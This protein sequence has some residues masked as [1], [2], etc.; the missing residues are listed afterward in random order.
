M[1]TLNSKFRD[2]RAMEAFVA[3]VS[4]GSMTGAGKALGISQ[5]A[6]TRLVRDLETYV[7]FDL[8]Q[9]NGPIISPTEQGMRFYEES[10]RVMANLDHLKERARAIK[11]SSISAIDIVATPTMAAGLVAPILARLSD[12][13]PK[14]VHIETTNAERVVHTV[15]QRT[16]DLGFS[17]FPV[18]HERLSCLAK[19]DSTLVAV[20][21]TGSIYDTGEPLPLSLFSDVRLATVGNSFRVRNQIMYALNEQNIRLKAEILTNSSLNAVM[22]ARSDLG[23]AICDPVTA[24]GVPVEGVTIRPLATHFKYSWGMFSALDSNMQ[25]HFTQLTD[26]FSDVSEDIVSKAANVR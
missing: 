23:I 4:C 5:P 2:I 13:L 8:F 26:A 20:V 14:L 16:A 10:Q 7:G 9:R 6:V 24:F 12:L 3:V 15:R 21:K 25:D 22:A 19:F 18:D 17:A 1:S 11:D